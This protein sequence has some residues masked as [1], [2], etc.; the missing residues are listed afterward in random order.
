MGVMEVYWGSGSPFAWRVLLALEVKKVG[1]ASRLLEFSK[2]EH[3]SPEFLSLNPRGKV[4]TI[5][6]GD[7]VLSESIAILAYL[8]RKTPNPP[9]FG[10]NPKAAGRIWKSVSE[11]ISYLEPQGFKIAG[12]IFFN[13]AGESADEIRSAVEPLHAELKRMEGALAQLPWLADEALS[14]ADIVAYPP[15]EILLRAASK[16]GASR[17]ELDLLPLDRRYPA[18]A[19][20]RERIRSLPGYERTYPPHWRDAPST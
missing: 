17:F 16:E 20:W 1:Y 6:D 5:R 7:F 15:I 18:I 9:L 10:R 8:D 11:T 4:P 12:P 13:K 2:R 14:A 19:S 3:R